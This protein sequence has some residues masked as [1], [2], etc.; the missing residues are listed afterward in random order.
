MA[1]LAIVDI[2]GLDVPEAAVEKDVAQ[3]ELFEAHMKWAKSDTGA[4]ESLVVLRWII[5]RC[6][7]SLKGYASMGSLPSRRSA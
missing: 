3:T 7:Y 2:G 1:N 6:D 4:L 5:V